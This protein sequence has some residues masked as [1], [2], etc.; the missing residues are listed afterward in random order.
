MNFASSVA[1]GIKVEI[2]DETGKPIPGFSLADSESH[3]GDSVERTVIWQNGADISAIAGRSIRLHFQLQDAD[4]Y[5]L[6]FSTAPKR[7]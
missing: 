1:G 4:L 3:F 6:K 5:S 7:P 2:Q